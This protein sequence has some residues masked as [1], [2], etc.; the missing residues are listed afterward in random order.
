MDLTHLLSIITHGFTLTLT[1]ACPASNPSSYQR[2][3]PEGVAL[4]ENVEKRRKPRFRNRPHLRQSLM[5]RLRAKLGAATR[6]KA[7][8][9]LRAAAFAAATWR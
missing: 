8:H 4:L 7:T 2:T 9:T 5:R 6:L 1:L 3:N